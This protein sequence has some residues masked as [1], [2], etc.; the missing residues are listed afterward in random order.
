MIMI[1]NE[2]GGGWREDL[3][4]VLKAQKR[5]CGILEFLQRKED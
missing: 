3:R 4:R 1:E 5:H 2:E